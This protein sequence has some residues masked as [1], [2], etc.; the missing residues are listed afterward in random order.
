MKDLKGYAVPTARFIGD[1]V[2]LTTEIVSKFIKANPTALDGLI[3]D[4]LVVGHL[5]KNK[6][7]ASSI[8]DRNVSNAVKTFQS[9]FEKEKLPALIEARYR[10]EHPE[11]TPEQIQIRELTMKLET[12]ENER[13]KIELGKVAKNL[14]TESGIVGAERF[15]YAVSG[16]DEDSIKANTKLLLA[17]LNLFLKQN[18]KLA[19]ANLGR[20]GEGAGDDGNDDH[21]SDELTKLMKELDE[22]KKT[23]GNS[24]K[25]VSLT[26]KIHELQQKLRA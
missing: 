8:F 11:E 18:S 4:D 12:A 2:E 16:D 25:V 23:V 5:E 10:K 24:L 14:L 13:K 3:T 19:M 26:R 7:L 17:D 22:A 9:N 6:E 20:D 21:N 15:E 1:E